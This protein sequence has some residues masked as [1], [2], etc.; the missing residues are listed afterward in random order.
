MSFI[1]DDASLFTRQK[2]AWRHQ[3]VGKG[4]GVLLRVD[5]TLAKLKQKLHDRDVEVVACWKV[6]CC[7]KRTCN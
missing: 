5:P 7:V 4:I 6:R 2:C 1:K 3:H